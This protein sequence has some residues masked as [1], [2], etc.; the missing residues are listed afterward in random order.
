MY[1]GFW[2]LQTHQGYTQASLKIFCVEDFVLCRI[3]RLLD[4]GAVLHRHSMMWCGIFFSISAVYGSFIEFLKHPVCC[5]VG[6]LG[7]HLSGTNSGL[8][9]SHHRPLRYQRQ[10]IIGQITSWI[11]PSL[12]Y[13]PDVRASSMK[14]AACCWMSWTLKMLHSHVTW[15]VVDMKDSFNVFWGK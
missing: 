2:V 4:I 14:T 6:C 1:I 13:P 12:S 3:R 9:I 15:F 5:S 8:L 11:Q 10:P 7:F